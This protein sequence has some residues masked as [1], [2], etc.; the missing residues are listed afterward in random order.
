MQ[1]QQ[2]QQQQTQPADANLLLQQVL[3]LIQKESSKIGLTNQDLGLDAAAGAMQNGAGAGGGL[4]FA[5]LIQLCYGKLSHKI[6]EVTQRRQKKKSLELEW[7]TLHARY[8]QKCLQENTAEWQRHYQTM[9]PIFRKHFGLFHNCIQIAAKNFVDAAM[10]YLQTHKQLALILPQARGFL[11]STVRDTHLIH[12]IIR[13]CGAFFADH[14]Q[15]IKQKDL[16]LA[17]LFRFLRDKLRE[18]KIWHD[19]SD[20]IKKL[21]IGNADTKQQYEY[22]QQ[23]FAEDQNIEAIVRKIP[24]H[25]Q[26]DILLHLKVMIQFSIQVGRIENFRQK[27]LEYIVDKEEHVHWTPVFPNQMQD[28]SKEQREDYVRAHREFLVDAAHI[29]LWQQPEF[30]TD[31]N[32][33]VE[34]VF[35]NL[36]KL[37]NSLIIK[38]HRVAHERATQH[39]DLNNNSNSSNHNKKS[40]DSF[41]QYAFDGID[42]LVEMIDETQ[43][44][45]EHLHKQ[46]FNVN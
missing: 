28:A 44:D 33:L 30:E 23:M 2:Q 42:A 20:L 25:V 21:Q 27:M 19:P 22:V 36:S 17:K 15:F 7:R 43:K 12:D 14:Q 10:L 34:A 39:Y 46:K 41:L 13:A 18:R 1:K 9:E 5:R 6:K 8:A 38:M 4:D 31:A 45:I 24:G 32:L 29:F 37:I 11:Y 40:P 35:A 26:H 3:G 16:T